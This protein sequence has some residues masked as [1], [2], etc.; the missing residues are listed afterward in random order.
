MKSNKKKNRNYVRQ[1]Q[2]QDLERKRVR[3]IT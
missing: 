3:I 1:D 2:G